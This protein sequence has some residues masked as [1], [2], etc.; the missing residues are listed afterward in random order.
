MQMSMPA[1]VAYNEE[2]RRRLGVR[3]SALWSWLI[4]LAIILASARGWIVLN[5]GIAAATVYH[6]TAGLL[7]ILTI[8]GFVKSRGRGNS[9]LAWLKV[10]MGLNLL[11]GIINI[12]G[13]LALG[14]PFDLGGF[15]LYLAPYIVYLFLGVPA[16]YLN[17][18]VTVITL[19]ISYS[20]C[21]NFYETSRGQEGFLNVYKY[22]QILRPDTFEAL[23][24]TGTIYRAS[25]YTGSYHDSA[26]ILGMAAAFFFLRFIIRG[27][28]ID[29][30]LS[31]VAMISMTMTQSAANI[32]VAI[33]TIAIFTGY[34]LLT[35]RK[36]KTIV[37][38]MLAMVFIGCVYARFGDVMSIFTK[39]VG[40]GGDWSGMV[41]GL[42]PSTLFQ[43]IPFFFL[44]HATAFSSGII[45]VESTFMKT[46]YQLGI[47]HTIIIFWMMLYPLQRFFKV[48]S[49][50]PEALPSA[51]AV[52]FG[53]MSLIH[54][55]SVF[56]ETN[57]FLF[58]TF[59][60]IC[61]MKI[62]HGASERG[63]NGKARSS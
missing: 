11:L 16:R 1:T 2:P 42:D 34:S 61:L 24:H 6:A 63:N 52:L 26:E 33:A 41:N 17:L 19:A 47:L 18:A 9:D 43:S 32:V 14:L 60:A 3:K 15:Y 54:Y 50:C 38:I 31:A 37:C 46:L 59:Y 13:D 23:S 10:L 48:R 12:A 28:I 55:G 5:L 57:I 62:R 51:A 7:L 21:D 49:F 29:L 44:G 25:G 45:D 22:N 40:S 8:Y 20:V 30:G 53:F 39:R 36:W 4:M 27:K 56:R 58:F 35:A